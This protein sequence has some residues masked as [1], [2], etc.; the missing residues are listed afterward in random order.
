VADAPP[1]SI[2][3]SYDGT[4][5]TPADDA[6]H[7]GVVYAPTSFTSEINAV[8]GT[9]QVVVRD[10]HVVYNFQTGR[11]IQLVIDGTPAWGGYLTQIA[12]RH[13]FPDT[14]APAWVLSGVDY[15]VV[16]D[17][18]VV[19]DVGSYTNQIESLPGDTKDGEALRQLLTDYS[20]MDDFTGGEIDDVV[21]VS[22]RADPSE[23]CDP[24][25]KWAWTQQGEKIR[26]TFDDFSRMSSA[27]YWI[28]GAKVVHYHSIETLLNSW[29]F[30][31]HPNNT[32][33]FGFRDAE[34]IEDGSTIVNDALIWGG[35]ELAGVGGT[36]F[37]RT[38]DSGSQSTH[39]R[40][41]IGETHVGEKNFGLQG[42]V[43][44]RANA[45]VLGP[46]GADIFNVQKGLR[47]PGWQVDATWF[48]HRVPGILHPGQIVPLDF[49]VFGDTRP[50]PLRSLSINFPTIKED[51]KTY[52]QYRGSF[53]LSMSDPFSLWSMLMRVQNRKVKPL[54]GAS[55]NASVS[56][57]F[58]AYGSFNPTHVSGL[59][60]KIPF[61]YISGT[62]MV[63]VAGLLLTPGDDYTETNHI[64]GTFTLDHSVSGRLYATCRTLSS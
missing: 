8:P 29:G 64:K 61:G 21:C 30:S 54:L 18:R 42:G 10:P 3:I 46:P 51:S 43:T 38:Q 13:F 31:D 56:T 63:Y 19:R 58:G 2:S 55:G 37:K 62:L 47:Y 53:A 20:D 60:Y 50:L 1:V 44:A 14:V 41:Q 35:S 49:S 9:C 11:E 34:M 23:D 6:G 28:D 33:S 25:E 12:R 7:T 24:D 39:G 52:V 26:V 4:P 16:F 45:I 59:I 17:K 48:H 5:I 15:N 27:M 22:P 57:S 40:W 32:T 36:V